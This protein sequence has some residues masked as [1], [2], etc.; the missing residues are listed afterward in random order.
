MENLGFNFSPDHGKKVK[1]GKRGAQTAKK[2]QKKAQ[3][4][5]VKKCIRKQA[6]RKRTVAQK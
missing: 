5:T 1:E 2:T 4:K 3:P 6:K